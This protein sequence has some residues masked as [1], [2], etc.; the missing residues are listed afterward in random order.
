M[1]NF[2]YDYIVNGIEL[3]ETRQAL[4]TSRCLPYNPTGKL[5][6]MEAKAI[7]KDGNEYYVSWIFEDDENK[8]L[9]DYDYSTPDDCKLV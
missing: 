2:T 7:D 3:K 4:P 9:D 5:F 8:D 6:E 1:T